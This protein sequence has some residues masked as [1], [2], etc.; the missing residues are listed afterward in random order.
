MC[1]NSGIYALMGTKTN[2]RALILFALAEASGP[3]TTIYLT[4][5][6]FETDIVKWCAMKALLKTTDTADM[7]LPV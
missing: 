4:W 2:P 7:Q 1:E 5:V 6:V 3:I